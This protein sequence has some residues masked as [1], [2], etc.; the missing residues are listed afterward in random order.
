VELFIRINTKNRGLP[1]TVTPLYILNAR[2]GAF[3]KDT[4]T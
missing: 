1:E 3:G 4:P 2:A